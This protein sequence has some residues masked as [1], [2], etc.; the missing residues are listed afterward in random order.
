MRAGDLLLAHSEKGETTLFRAAPDFQLVAK[1][2]L[3]DPG[4]MATPAVT[5][6]R[7]LLRTDHALYCLGLPR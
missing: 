5:D 1:N 6:G 3:S 4:G 2:R 7:I